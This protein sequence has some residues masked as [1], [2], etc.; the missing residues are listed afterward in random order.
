M[1]GVV[2]S[3]LCAAVGVATFAVSYLVMEQARGMRPADVAKVF[4]QLSSVGP[5]AI[6]RVRE[7]EHRRRREVIQDMPLFLDI[8]TL[9]I[10]AGLSFDSSL[11]LYC[12]RYQT[13]L[14]RMMS[15][16]VLSWRMG[17]AGRSDALWEVAHQ[18]GVP[19]MERFASTVT[20]ALAFGTPLAEALSR[21]AQVIRDEQ[22]S[23]TEEEI[24]RVPV[25]MLIP[26]GTL[27]V[28]AMLL[29]ILGPLLGPALSMG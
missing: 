8:V 5:V 24:E 22:R 26:L 29:A 10:S 4:L 13:E 25:K 14:A 11:E 7:R 16:A 12:D 18:T 2:T 23:Q 21:Q 17:V 27:I 6:A 20:E 9:G 3:V 28:P 15:Q 19:A 1:T